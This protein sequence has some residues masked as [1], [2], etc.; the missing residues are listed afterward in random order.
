MVVH[1]K[2]DKNDYSTL[3]LRGITRLRNGK[4]AEF[5]ELNQWIQDYNH[6]NQL[7]KIKTFAMFRMWKAFATWRKNVRTR[8]M[9][10]CQKSLKENLFL[11]HTSLGPALLEVKKL[12]EAICEKELMV[13]IDSGTTYTLQE[14]KDCQLAKMGLVSGHS[15]VQYCVI[16]SIGVNESCSIP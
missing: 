14:F 4:E 10:R 15:H 1:S 5:T 13:A 12:A 3:S 9:N 6:F 2:V 11:L 16:L 8:K 7:L